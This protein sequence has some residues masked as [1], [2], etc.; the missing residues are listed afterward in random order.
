[1]VCLL[2]RYEDSKHVPKIIKKY[3]EFSG[4]ELLKKNPSLDEKLSKLLEADDEAK[5]EPNSTES[6]QETQGTDDYKA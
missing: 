6:E 5:R 1:M 2:D 3:I 4:N